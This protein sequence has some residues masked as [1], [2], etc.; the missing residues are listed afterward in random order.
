MLD[1]LNDI[2][3]RLINVEMCIIFQQQ[4]TYLEHQQQYETASQ[5]QQQTQL[6]ATSTS[7]TSGRPKSGG[8]I[9]LGAQQSQQAAGSRQTGSSGS[10]MT[11]PQQ[12]Q[13]AQQR[14]S[15]STTPK[16]P[17]PA[18][19]TTP[20][21][22]TT[23]VIIPPPPLIAHQTQQPIGNGHSHNN[24][25]NHHTN[26]ST[27]HNHS[28]NST[29]NHHNSFKK[30]KSANNFSRLSNHHTN[31]TNSNS[32]K[33]NYSTSKTLSK[34]FSSRNINFVKKPFL[35]ASSSTGIKSSIHQPYQS[36]QPYSLQVKT[37]KRSSGLQHS[38]KSTASSTAK[39][40]QSVKAMSLEEGDNV[41]QRYSSTATTLLST[42]SEPNISTQEDTGL[43]QVKMEL[44]EP[45]QRQEASQI[46][47]E[48]AESYTEEGSEEGERPSKQSMLKKPSS[49]LSA[50]TTP[51]NTSTM[52]SGQILQ[53]AST[54]S[55]MD[56]PDENIET[57]TDSET[58]EYTLSN[59]NE[60][61]SLIQALA[62]QHQHQQLQLQHRQHQSRLQQPSQ[63]I[64]D[65]QDDEQSKSTQ[66]ADSPNLNFMYPPGSSAAIMGSSKGTPM[67]GDATPSGILSK[68][69]PHS[70]LISTIQTIQQQQMHQHMSQQAAA[71]AGPSSSSAANISTAELNAIATDESTGQLLLGDH[72][73]RRTF[74][75]SK[76]RGNFAALLVQQLYNKQE[77]ITSN[78]MGTRGKRQLSPR[79]MIVVKRITFKMYPSTNEKEEELIWKKECV[80]AI[81]SKN[82][83]IRI[84][85]GTIS[86]LSGTTLSSNPISNPG[87]GNMR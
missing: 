14:S 10:P 69:S 84:N 16:Q 63:M 19:P 17:P 2:E 6:P 87:G 22:V 49:G 9:S 66:S 31:T 44:D 73:I 36:E 47:Q 51:T 4:L 77:R 32:H 76:S 21:I 75:I 78:V 54:S 18:P 29:T 61:S 28:N 33:F 72:D 11:T 59:P 81:D 27:N 13:P 50:T 26:N 34:L 55:Q 1:K 79:R 35:K 7:S 23:G 39:Q 15:P 40:K 46:V 80:K 86:N 3:K 64:T 68:L 8:S 58:E 20:S 25:T 74:A 70:S 43:T 45:G 62:Q 37:E 12:Q 60:V 71:A 24:K 65:E 30:F 41:R 5:Q 52:T 38:Q 83:K 48:M 85:P 82:R 42:A 67:P 57:D 53:Q 56:D